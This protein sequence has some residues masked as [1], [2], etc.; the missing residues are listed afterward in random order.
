MRRF[1]PSRR[2][3]GWLALGAGWALLLTAA[4]WL[5]PVLQHRWSPDI[6]ARLALFAFGHS[7]FVHAAGW[8]GWRRLWGFGVA[9]AA[10]GV[11]LLH[12]YAASDMGGWEDLIGAMALTTV[13]VIGVAA[14]LL[15]EVAGAVWAW[16]KRKNRRPGGPG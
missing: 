7:V 10:I 4:L 16:Q 12:G 1:V 14:G 13:T 9:G 11:A 5:H 15:A 6:A 2:S 8:F 3:G